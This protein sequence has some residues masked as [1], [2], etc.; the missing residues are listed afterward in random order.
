[1]R[2]STHLLI[3]DPQRDFCDLADDMCPPTVA[4]ALPIPGADADLRRLAALLDA[5]GHAID[6]ITITLDTHQ[7]IDIAHAPF[8]RRG[9]GRE[10]P[11]FTP[12]TAA[13][14]RSGVYVPK[15]PSWTAWVLHYAEALEAAGRYTLMAWPVHCVDG[16]WGHAM[17]TILA[18]AVTRWESAFG[19]TVALLRK[20]MNPKT[21]HYSIVQAEVPDPDDPTTLPNHQLLEVLRRADRVVV[22]GEA[23]SHCVRASVEHLVAYVEPERLVLLQDCM[24]P[25][26]GFAE[27]HAA[28]LAD[29]AARGVR[30]ADSQRFMAELAIDRSFAP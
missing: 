8:W 29:M 10:V 25:V 1:M 23:G 12:I 22:A 14:V 13:E 19:K 27:E 4:P 11:A 26:T 24:S 20:G 30:V 6:A 7:L 16:T 2:F 17:H 3:V 15:D 5:A 18:E 9:D 21:E 28:F